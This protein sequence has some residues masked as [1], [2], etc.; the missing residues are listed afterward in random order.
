MQKQKWTVKRL[1]VDAM[2]TA[3]CT[4]LGMVALDFISM[5]I[6]FESLPVLIGA[7]LFGPVDGVAIGLIGTLLYQLLR[8]GV[9][10][11]TLLWMLPYGVCGLLVGW[12]AA[13]RKF[14]LSLGQLMGV[15]VVN[16]LLI[17]AL[18]TGVIYVDSMIYGYYSKAVVFGMLIPRIALSIGK[19]IVF[20]LLLPYLLKAARKALRMELPGE[21]T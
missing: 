14:N 13:R 8:Y 1:A 5:K 15:T 19:G 11:T 21:Q 18:N 9:S 17:T 20:A 16:E 7:L 6:T 10:A 3:M 4:V 12:Y 2:F